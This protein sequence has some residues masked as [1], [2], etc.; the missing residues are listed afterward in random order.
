MNT[1]QDFYPTV[2]LFLQDISH[3]AEEGLWKEF[4]RQIDLFD[5]FCREHKVELQLDNTKPLFPT[6]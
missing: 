6:C 2:R 5:A 4:Y 1:P 3:L